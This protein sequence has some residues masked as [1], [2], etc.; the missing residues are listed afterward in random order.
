MT[1]YVYVQWWIHS[2]IP[3]RQ[4]E[5]VVAY[6]SAAMGDFN[7]FISLLATIYVLNNF[8]SCTVNPSCILYPLHYAALSA[9][10][11]DKS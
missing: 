8:F 11:V 4:G 1:I 10:D 2:K 6:Q 7:C 9:P 3:L 5:E